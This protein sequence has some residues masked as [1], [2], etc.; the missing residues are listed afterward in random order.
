MKIFLKFYKARRE[1]RRNKKKG[2]K[3]LFFSFKI[4]P[5]N[6]WLGGI[7]KTFFKHLI[8]IYYLI[9]LL[10]GCGKGTKDEQALSRLYHDY[11]NAIQDE[12][13]EALKGFITSERQKE[14]LGE[15]AG[16]KLKMIKDLLPSD[17]KVTKT[18]VSGTTAVLEVDGQMQGQKMTGKVEFLKEEEEWKIAKESWTMKLEMDTGE[19][20]GFAAA[21]EPFM[22]DPDGHIE[23]MRL[24]GV[25]L[26]KT[27]E[28]SEGSH[29]GHG[30]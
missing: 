12:D 22:K 7:M 2:L 25:K 1:R 23:K 30:H 26:E 21:A 5:R 10:T 14:V 16:M 9:F 29:E 19:S 4:H 8:I 28:S 6:S 17:I 24:K 11:H 27:P 15:G 3:Y 13:M 18:T 20:T